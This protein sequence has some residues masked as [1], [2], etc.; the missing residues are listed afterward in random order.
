ME[1]VRDPFGDTFRPLG[2]ESIAMMRSER[3]ADIDRN[4]VFM[5]IPM[6]DGQCEGACCPE[7]KTG[8]V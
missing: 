3:L 6:R 2:C 7:A 8:G 4:M 1:P 5:D